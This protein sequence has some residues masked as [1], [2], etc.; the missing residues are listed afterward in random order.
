MTARTGEKEKRK[1]GRRSS[2]ELPADEKERR[3][4]RA[5]TM[6]RVEENKCEAV[7]E[8]ARANRIIGGIYGNSRRNRCVSGADA[9][10]NNGA[11]NLAAK[12][13][14]YPSG[15]LGGDAPIGS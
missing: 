1:D 5:A 14:Q 8:G 9:A 2:D 3:E 13:A 11:I 6:E 4:D 15:S 12:N 10:I 7:R